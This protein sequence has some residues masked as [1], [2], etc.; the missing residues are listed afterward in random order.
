MWKKLPVKPRYEV[1]TVGVAAI[2]A[3]ISNNHC[4]LYRL[5]HVKI[6]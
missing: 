2:A 1:G 4:Y 6:N 5:F 3:I